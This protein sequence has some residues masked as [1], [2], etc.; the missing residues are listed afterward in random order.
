MEIQSGNERLLEEVLNDYKPFIKRAV[1]SVCKR[2]IYESD[3]EY[4]IGLMA[5]HESI[6][7]FEVSKGS[8]LLAFSEVV[9]SRKIIDFIRKNQREKSVPY[10]FIEVDE[11]L[12]GPN[13][14]EKDQ[15]MD[16][17][18]AKEL[19]LERKNEILDFARLLEQYGLSFQEIVNQSPKHEDAR[20][21]AISI[22]SLIAV[23]PEW[24]DYLKKKKR[25]P[26]KEIEKQVSVSRKTIERNRK[27]IIAIV[28]LLD[29]EFIY[30]QQYMKERF[31][32]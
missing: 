12:D 20:Q 25:L 5:F 27:Y 4:S 10:S 7:K 3:D 13:L 30:L 11:E 23:S 9:I 19:A 6:M 17:Y 1:S 8:S 18:R 31:E 24:L 26:L 2:Y 15:A 14:I 29:G 32:Q 28:L 22:A 21:N 16:D